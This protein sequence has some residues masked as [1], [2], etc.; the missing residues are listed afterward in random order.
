MF[1][2]ELVQFQKENPTELFC[3]GSKVTL[4]SEPVPPWPS[5]IQSAC[6]TRQVVGEVREEVI[7]ADSCVAVCSPLT[8]RKIQ[9]GVGLN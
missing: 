4:D 6:G 5:K 3:R 2:K 9:V 7:W 1:Q 8:P